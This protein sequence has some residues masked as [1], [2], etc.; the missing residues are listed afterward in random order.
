MIDRKLKKQRTNTAGRNRKEND[1]PIKDIS[2]Q[3]RKQGF[4]SVMWN[5]E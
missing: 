4:L 1:F 5:V 2:H 3:M